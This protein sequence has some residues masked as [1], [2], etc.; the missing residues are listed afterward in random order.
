M[1]DHP[2]DADI[3][4]SNLF[5]PRKAQQAIHPPVNVFDGAVD[6]PDGEKIGYRLYVHKVDSP[7][8]LY[9]HGNGEVVSDYDAI[10]TMYHDIGVSLL[11]VD[12]RGYGWSTGTPLTSKMLPDAKAVLDGLP[13]IIKQG[14][15]LE[16]VSLFIKGR[17]LGSA[18][19]IYLALV[20]PEAFKG[21]IIESGFADT[22]S[23]FKRL[24]IE[25]PV[26]YIGDDSLPLDNVGK[27]ERVQL[28]LLV[29][30]GER[31]NL[32]P[33]EHGQELFDASPVDDKTILRITG[34]GH[35]DILWMGQ[36]RYFEAMRQ[37]VRDHV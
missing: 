9:F 35:N 30:H 23:L 31:D 4:V 28:P 27:M 24:R 19:A 6:T 22:P 32:L 12:Y 13:E 14:G 26:E 15:L 2:F 37:F 1:S 20:A 10:S 18:P 25:M 5:F 34:A 3:I 8:I 33:V 29:I 21:L 16:D 11:V 7:L 17:S 36:Q